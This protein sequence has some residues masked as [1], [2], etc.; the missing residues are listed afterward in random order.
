MVEEWFLIVTIELEDEYLWQTRKNS[1]TEKNKRFL[2]WQTYE[3]L[4]ITIHSLI[5]A[6]KYLLGIG[7]S[8]FNRIF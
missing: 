3:G 4:Q 2:S 8:F 7:I 6:V 1:Q 5:E